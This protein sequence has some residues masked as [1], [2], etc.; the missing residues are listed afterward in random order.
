[1]LLGPPLSAQSLPDCAATPRARAIPTARRMR[2]FIARCYHRAMKTA[3]WILLLIGVAAMAQRAGKPGEFDYYLLTLSWSPQF[4]AGHWNDPQ[5]T[6]P[7][8]FGFVVHGMWP[9]FKNGSWPES[10]STSPGL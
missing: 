3:R 6:G 10:C 1:M 5:C 9:Q 8:K 7:R 2:C 4:C